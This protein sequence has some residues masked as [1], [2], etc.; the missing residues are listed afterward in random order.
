MRILILSLCLSIP[1]ISCSQQQAA[2][3]STKEDLSEGMLYSHKDIQELK[4]TADS[5]NLRFLQ[6]VPDPVYYSLPQ[7]QATAM[8]FIIEAK[9]ASLVE[10]RLKQGIS[11]QQLS[12][13]FPGIKIKDSSHVV[14]SYQ[15]GYDNY[16]KKYITT[17][18][19]G[20]GDGFSPTDLDQ[21]PV[22]GNWIYSSNDTD[23]TGSISID[24]WLPDKPFVTIKLP[25]EYAKMIQ[26]ADCMIDTTTRLMLGKG[27][28]P[29]E[30]NKPF[31]ALEGIVYRKTNKNVDPQYDT[32]L[33]E[34]DIKYIQREYYKNDSIKLLLNLAVKEALEKGNGNGTL[35]EAATGIYSLDTVLLMKRSRTVYGNCSHDDAPIRHARDIA[36]LASQTHQWP[37]F[38]RAHL[39]IMNDQFERMSDADYA[40]ARRKTHLRELELLD[41]PAQQLL[42]G[43]VFMASNLSS[44]H[45]TGNIQRIGRAF[46]E[47]GYAAAFEKQIKSIMKD[48]NLDPFNQC[49]FLLLYTSYC[50]HQP[51]ESVTKSKVNELK[52]TAA[53][54][55]EYIRAGINAL[56]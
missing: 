51:L 42:F 15:T 27:G 47:S 50:Y 19:S 20:N 36:V 37:V 9:K 34:N 1:I 46:T 8:T 33:N 26:Y 25:A 32:Y 30:E 13:E 17:L 2:K 5:L 14:L 10:A 43:T 35:E 12:K 39:N 22:G 52:A 29:E 54:Y 28:F 31:E 49:I 48:K 3:R 21:P 41:I 7:T 4:R 55:P 16:R 11:I 45:Y 40:E 53:A 44:S 18:Y 6:C 23:D 56:E 24:A 38:I